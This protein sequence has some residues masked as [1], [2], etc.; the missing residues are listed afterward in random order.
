MVVK[1]Q[2]HLLEDNEIFSRYLRGTYTPKP[3]N[4]DGSPYLTDEYSTSL[5]Y[6]Q[7]KEPFHALARYNVVKEIMEVLVEHQNYIL[8]DAIDIKMDGHFYRKFSYRNGDKELRQ[9]YF[10]VISDDSEFGAVTLLEKPLKKVKPGEAAGPMRPATNPYYVDNSELYIRFE[11]SNY[12]H[13]VEKSTR[14]FIKLF[15]KEHRAK[16]KSFM[17]EKRLKSKTAEDVLEVVTFYN[18]LEANK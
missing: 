12:A 16:V 9:G 3:T 8:Q 5:L 7:D 13:Q 14:N 15:P 17:K 2:E 1:Q 18:S 10:K 4:I 6:F 11:N